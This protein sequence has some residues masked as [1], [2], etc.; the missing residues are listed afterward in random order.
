MYP[1]LKCPNQYDFVINFF[2]NENL[3]EWEGNKVNIRRCQQASGKAGT[4]EEHHIMDAKANLCYCDTPGCNGANNMFPQ[5]ITFL[6][7]ICG[8]LVMMALK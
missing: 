1:L 2:I 3:L 4:C 5:S 7:G 8:L 6:L